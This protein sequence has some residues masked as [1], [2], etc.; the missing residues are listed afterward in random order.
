MGNLPGENNGGMKAISA[1]AANE[2]GE[3]SKGANHES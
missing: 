1:V 2:E 3:N